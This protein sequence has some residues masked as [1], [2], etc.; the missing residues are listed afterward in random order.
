MLKAEVEHWLD[1]GH[2]TFWFI[3]RED[4]FDVFLQDPKDKRAVKV[5]R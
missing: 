2:G 5:T 4:G 1:R 3:E